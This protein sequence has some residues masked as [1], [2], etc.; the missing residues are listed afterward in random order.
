VQAVARVAGDRLNLSARSSK[1][2]RQPRSQV[3]RA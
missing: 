2:N 3:W 1:W